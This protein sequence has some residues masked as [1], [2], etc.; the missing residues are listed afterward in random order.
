[1]AKTVTES[2]N[3]G[4]KTQAAVIKFHNAHTQYRSAGTT[5][6][7]AIGPKGWAA[8]HRLAYDK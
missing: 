8:L 7:P 5:S 3:Y 4:P 1:M 2:P 6:D